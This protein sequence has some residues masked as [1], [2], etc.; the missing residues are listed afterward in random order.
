MATFTALGR[1]LPADWAPDLDPIVSVNPSLPVDQTDHFR[2]YVT[3]QRIYKSR[4]CGIYG[5][6]WRVNGNAWLT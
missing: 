1:Q 5:D 3:R 4:V 6:G 2:L